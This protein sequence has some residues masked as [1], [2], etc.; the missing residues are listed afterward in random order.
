MGSAAVALPKGFGG[1]GLAEVMKLVGLPSETESTPKQLSG[2]AEELQKSVVL[3]I[4]DLVRR[5]LEARTA[6]D[7]T[8]IRDDV[9]RQ[10]YAAM[11]ALG[12]LLRI[13]VPSH[14]ME[15]LAAE[16]LSSLEGEFRDHG[17][18][19]FGADLCE[20]GLFTVWTLRKINDLAQ[21]IVKS[22]PTEVKASDAEK[23]NKFATWALWSRFHVDC[24]VKSMRTHKPIY[25]EV[26][27]PIRDGLR[28]AVDAY[29][30]LRQS[31][32]SM[33]ALPEPEIAPIPWD[34]DDEYLLVDSTRD[35]EQ[36]PV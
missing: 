22:P 8:S 16:S 6:E 13:I 32:D 23:A 29:A 7:F 9:F 2:A 3:I 33:V 25:P 15:R 24:L 17:I 5:A 31:V 12:Q 26:V 10:Y 1:V 21:E 18:T 28:G 20:R 34:S 11:L 14:S 19:T 36:E 4:D 30:W 27:E 35:M